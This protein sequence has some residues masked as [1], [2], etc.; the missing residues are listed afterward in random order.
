MA[1]SDE[2][3]RAIKAGEVGR[4]RELLGAQPALAAVRDAGGVSMVLLALYHQRPDV[5]EAVL[6]AGPPLDVF[7]AAAT[8][9]LDRLR[10]LLEAEPGAANAWAADGFFPLGLAC[11]FR[12][13]A[14][15]RLLI[16]AGAD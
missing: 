1:T 14:A 16:E 4:V 9:R 11:F 15:A 12:Q 2:L 8:G 13:P 3:A 10:V 5:A 7:D 6:E